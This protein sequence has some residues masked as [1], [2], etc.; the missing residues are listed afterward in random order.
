[1]TGL[2]LVLALA[3]TML[4]IFLSAPAHPPICTKWGG[5]NLPRG[6]HPVCMEWRHDDR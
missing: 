2:W 4:W 6:N 3:V 5:S 1:M